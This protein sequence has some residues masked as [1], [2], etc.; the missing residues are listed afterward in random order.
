MC[1]AMGSICTVGG[2]EFAE[3]LSA[4]VQTI[5]L[6]PMTKARASPQ[7]HPNPHPNPIPHPIPDRAAT[8]TR[9]THDTNDTRHAARRHATPRARRVQ[10]RAERERARAML[11]RP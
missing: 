7:P 4:D 1:L 8:H 11:T 3:T 9:A 5:L 2:R 6:A 10:T